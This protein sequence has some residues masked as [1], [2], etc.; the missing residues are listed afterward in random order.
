MVGGRGGRKHYSLKP[1]KPS[2]L[3]QSDFLSQFYALTERI[4]ELKAEEGIAD[5]V[6]SIASDF[7]DLGSEQ[8]DKKSNMPDALQDGDTGQM[9]EERKE[10]CESIADE[11]EGLTLDD[12]DKEEGQ[13]DDEY[14]QSK[15]EEVQ[16]VDVDAP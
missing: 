4:D 12:S 9:L 6:S 7:R 14:W 15:L 1:P 5:E 8:E 11:L 16:G 10:K 13:D 3:T 2:Q